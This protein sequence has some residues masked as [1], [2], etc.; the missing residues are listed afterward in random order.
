MAILFGF[1]DSRIRWTALVNTD[2]SATDGR[3]PDQILK[4]LPLNICKDLINLETPMEPNPIL[5]IA[6][7]ACRAPWFSGKGFGKI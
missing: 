5:G 1:S 4:P 7:K 6:P 2:P 3:F